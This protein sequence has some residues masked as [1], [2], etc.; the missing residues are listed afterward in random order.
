VNAR[1]P[2]AGPISSWSLRGRNISISFSPAVVDHIR[3]D[4]RTRRENA[5]GLLVGVWW[6]DPPQRQCLI[7]SCTPIEDRPGLPPNS[8]FEFGQAFASWQEDRGAMAPMGVYVYHEGDTEAFYEQCLRGVPLHPD[9]PAP[10][11]VCLTNGIDGGRARLVAETGGGRFIRSECVI[12]RLWHPTGAE[13]PSA[14]SPDSGAAAAGAGATPFP[15]TTAGGAPYP[16][17]RA[18]AA[19]V[20]AAPALEPPQPVMR[21]ID[22]DAGTLRGPV[23]QP[24]M[25][26]KLTLNV[27]A[28]IL[29]GAAVAIFAIWRFTGTDGT[30]PVPASSVNVIRSADAG[31]DLRVT[32][33]G[34]DLEITWNRQ[35]A[36]ATNA[37]AGFLYITDSGERTDILLEQV[38]LKTG[39]VLYRPRSRDIEIRLELMTADQTAVREALKIIGGG[40]ARTSTADS[41]AM[42]FSP[43]RERSPSEA[44]P[45]PA[46]LKPP[47]PSPATNQAQPA[48]APAHDP[49]AVELSSSAALPPAPVVDQISVPAPRTAAPTLSEP[50]APQNPVGTTE[51]RE[52]REGSANAAE[53]ANVQ[54]PDAFPT[55]ARSA[56][57]TGAIPR[58]QVD[59]V[60]PTN[61][62]SLVKSDMAIPVTLTVDEQGRVK[63]AA[64]AAQDSSIGR[65]L[66]AQAVEAAKQ[67]RFE[68]ASV[69]GVPTTSRYVIT[70]RFTKQ[71]GR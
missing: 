25:L 12:P 18:A 56:D 53:A 47:E 24:D 44:A 45:Q 39:R 35:T 48:R 37:R 36:A 33:S 19:A 38:H 41:G 57:T 60:V 68:P 21:G 64:A 34:S 13:R 16:A 15:T 2:P 62:R 59:P 10:V 5:R 23:E 27:P 58:R 14:P 55:T 65:Y 71:R 50:S 26:R 8:L 63:S 43:R 17:A 28:V 29:L 51:Q 46:R 70:F 61:V 9:I 40:T 11:A 52:R 67:W 20:R 54:V 31:L 69:N 32:R 66:A 1:I 49:P 30:K 3:H 6:A 22:S 42:I 7:I 4:V